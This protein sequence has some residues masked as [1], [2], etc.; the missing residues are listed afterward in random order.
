MYLAIRWLCVFTVRGSRPTRGP[1]AHPLAKSQSVCR[2][3][4]LVQF[5]DELFG[6]ATCCGLC[7]V[8]AR[9]PLS[10]LAIAIRRAPARDLALG[11]AHGHRRDRA[12]DA[13]VGARST[14]GGDR[15][16]VVRARRIAA[17]DGEPEPA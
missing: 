7:A 8:D 2:D 3:E 15:E 16:Q 14:L 6:G 9:L 12:C 5:G 11:V 1:D 4:T 17:L 13:G 10:V